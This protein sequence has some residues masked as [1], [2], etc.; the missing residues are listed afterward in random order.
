MDG[1]GEEAEE[2]EEEE[3]EEVMLATGR[4]VSRPRVKSRGDFLLRCFAFADHQ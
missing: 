1:D 4:Q 3:E 2:E